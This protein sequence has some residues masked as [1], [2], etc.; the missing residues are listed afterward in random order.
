MAGGV[1]KIHRRDPRGFDFS[2]DV[3]D[4]AHTGTT[5]GHARRLKGS[6]RWNS[7]PDMGSCE[8]TFHESRS[9]WTIREKGSC[10]HGMGTSFD[11]TFVKQLPGPK[12]SFDC[13]S[14]STPDEALICKDEV[15]ASLDWEMAR[16]RAAQPRDREDAKRLEASQRAWLT[17]RG[18]CAR[19][20]TSSDAEQ[21]HAIV[22]LTRSY[23]ARLDE[24]DRADGR[25]VDS[26]F[27]RLRERVAHGERIGLAEAPRAA[28]ALRVLLGARY[29][30][31]TGIFGN[32]TFHEEDG[33]MIATGGPRGLF[34]I[35]EAWVAIGANDDAWIG[36]LDVEK[37]PD[38]GLPSRLELHVPEAQKDRL[39]PAAFDEWR[40]RFAAVPVRRIL[41]TW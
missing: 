25:K 27:R 12:P 2:L 28:G 6:F 8:L 39:P 18:A 38:G 20:A 11:G 19:K 21:E 10:P 31:M 32:A 34:T 40:E 3:W 5:D 17:A 30:M 33:Y 16:V 14:A 1:F 13:A 29:E 23:L 37:T 24:L 15:L 36:I 22:C 9:T 7:E 4:G 41:A 26:R 35:M